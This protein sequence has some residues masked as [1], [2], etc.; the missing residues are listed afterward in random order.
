MFEF[1]HGSLH[2]PGQFK[3]EDTEKVVDRWDEFCN[4]NHIIVVGPITDQD[5]GWTPSDTDLVLEA[6]RDVTANYTVDKSRIVA[7]GSGNGGQMAFNLGFKAR[8]VFRGVAAHSAVL[9]E[10]QDNVASQ[11][12]AFHV[13]GGD[14][15]PVIKAI[16]ETRNRLVQRHFPV[17]SGL[18]STS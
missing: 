1:A 10:P 6:V 12:L 15:D 13:S 9:T 11:R 7:H 17:F 14:R 16:A 3:D 8:D 4:E 18:R 5:G 2:L